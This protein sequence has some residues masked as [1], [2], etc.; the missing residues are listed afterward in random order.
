MFVKCASLVVRVLVVLYLYRC[1]F[2]CLL[3]TKVLYIL[4]LPVFFF[5]AFVQL[6]T[7]KCRIRLKT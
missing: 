4:L 2:V 3:R 5:I 7:K 6:S 1:C